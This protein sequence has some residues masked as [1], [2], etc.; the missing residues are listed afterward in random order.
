MDLFKVINT[1]FSCRAYL[2]KPVDPEIVKEVIELANRKP[3]AA[4]DNEKGAE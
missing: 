1:R 2:D 4:N 3:A